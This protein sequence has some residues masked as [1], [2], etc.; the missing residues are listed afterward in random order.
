MKVFSATSM[1]LLARRTTIVISPS[2]LCVSW[3]LYFVLSAQPVVVKS[4]TP[5]SSFELAVSAAS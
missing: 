5:T 3:N 1:L 4:S 2:A